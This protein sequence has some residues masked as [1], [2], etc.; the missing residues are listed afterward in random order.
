MKGRGV[1]TPSKHDIHNGTEVPAPK[2]YKRTKV[3]VIPEEWEVVRLGDVLKEKP[4]YGINA[5][6]VDYSKN[7]PR[8]L[9]ITDFD[10]DG[11]IDPEKKVSVNDEN[12]RN[13]IL[14]EN[15]LVF[16]RTGATVGKSY[17]YK[18]EDGELVY[19]GFLI[20]ITPDNHK[21]N[22]VFLRNYVSTN[23]YWSWVRYMSARSG[24]PGINGKEYALLPIPLPP[25]PEQ[26]KIAEILSTW[27][28]A[29]EKL[30]ALIEAKE[31]LK[32]GLMQKLLSGEVRF[33][34]FSGEWEEVRLGD[35][36]SFISGGTPATSNTEYWQ[37]KTPWISSS[38]LTEDSIYRIRKN[39]H[40][41][42]KAIKNSTTNKVPKNS[43]L[44][45]SRVGVGK[46]AIADEELCIS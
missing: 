3:G 15:D 34:G 14:Q 33:P 39:R 17:L 6:A 21:L 46:V 10:D 18:K 22:S 32:K 4:K 30:E 11:K 29:I 2:G 44:I 45:V 31:R 8:Y 9:R 24:Q 42:E 23:K 37:G 7:L 40:I 26:Q 36:G 28:R 19:A 41:T 43:I 12:Y 38:D 13:F 16:A 20:K 1:L 27:D 35:V 25:L 5:P